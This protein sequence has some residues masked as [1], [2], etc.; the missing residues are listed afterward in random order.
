ML[1]RIFVD[2]DPS[3][4]GIILAYLRDDKIQASALKNVELEDM[5]DEFDFYKLQVPEEL[6]S[7]Y[8]LLIFVIYLI[9]QDS[10]IRS[11]CCTRT[12]STW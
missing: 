12:T 7:I 11:P 6:V 8:Y 9:I 4:F 10:S 3:Y 1:S 5:Q 2:H